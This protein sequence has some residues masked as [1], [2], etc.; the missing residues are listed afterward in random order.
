MDKTIAFFDILNESDIQW[1]LNNGIHKADKEAL[2]NN[3]PISTETSDRIVA[4]FR[5]MLLTMNT[6]IGESSPVNPND[7]EVFGYK[8]QREMLPYI[9]LA[10]SAER[11][12]AKP[13]GYAGDYMTIQN[14]YNNN[15]SGKCAVGIIM[16]RCFLDDPNIKA[17]RNRRRLLVEEINNT[18][19][20]CGGSLT[21][22]TSLACGPAAEVFD[23][24]KTLAESL[25]KRECT[26]IRFEQEQIN[27]FA[28]CVK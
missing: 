27:M 11:M 4:S 21:Y 22:I 14:M 6:E 19:A 3:D 26:N 7:N 9:L 15:P 23:V 16:D 2:Q 28:E 1:F 25:F 12:Y 20:S 17:V 18:I 13:R 5:K 10:D 24:Y 8:C